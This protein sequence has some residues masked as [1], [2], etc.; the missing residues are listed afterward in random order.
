MAT[1]P[2]D[3]IDGAGPSPLPP[4]SRGGPSFTTTSR[5]DEVNNV[6]TW[7]RRIRAASKAY[8]SWADEYQVEQLERMY[9]GFQWGRQGNE[10]RPQDRYVVNLIFGDAETKMPALLFQRPSV[11]VQARPSLADDPSAG[12]QARVQ[13]VKDTAD[14]I[15][16]DPRSGFRVAH[17]LALKDSLFRFGVIAAFYDQDPMLTRDQE[18]MPPRKRNKDTEGVERPDLDETEGVDGT[19]GEMDE[20]PSP[21]PSLATPEPVAARIVYRWI[22]SKQFRVP[23]QNCNTLEENSWCGFFT[24]ESFDDVKNNNFFDPEAREQLT[25]GSA[26]AEFER[27]EMIQPP[28]QGSTASASNSRP[29]EDTTEA[30]Q[31]W[32]LWDIREKKR[33]VIS[34][35]SP[36]PLLSPEPYTTLPFSVLSFFER[37]GSFYPVPITWNW[38]HPQEEI[39]R[40]REDARIHRRRFYR[41]YLMRENAI[42][43]PELEKL[44]T[45]GDGVVAKVAGAGNG[46]LSD[47]LIP[48][49]DAPRDSNAYADA[50][51]LMQDM[52]L[53]S[54]VGGEQKGT[55][56][57]KTATQAALVES[58]ARLRQGWEKEVV[59]IWLASSITKCI[60]TAI[61]FFPVDYWIKVN[62]DTTGVGGAEEAFRVSGVWQ[63]IKLSDLNTFEWELAVD[64]ETL[65]PESSD[66]QRQQWSQVLGVFSQPQIMLFLLCS[67]MVLKKTL[68]LYGVRSSKDVSDVKRAMQVCLLANGLQVAVSAAEQANAISA[69]EDG[70]RGPGGGGMFDLGGLLPG[71]GG[72]ALPGGG[73]PTQIAQG[74]AGALATPGAGAGAPGPKGSPLMQLLAGLIGQGAGQ[75]GGMMG[76]GGR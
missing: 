72:G 5:T 50:Q 73:T 76:G 69:Q 48:V 37:L 6:K 19:N 21:F 75:V 68:A 44:E 64:V 43:Q 38:K 53:M 7:L 61:E 27:P 55:A 31:V 30:V 11:I 47:V 13:L 16:A 2:V 63:R 65:A 3:D 23:A 36:L 10:L 8:K 35:S 34:P 41:R 45:G 62:V 28:G 56:D 58:N 42:D 67:D 59:A 33:M 20:A 15:N 17:R 4:R 26:V 49:Q 32:W 71:A 18:R 52:R 74:G 57:A 40:E 66:L 1:P 22:P 12:I 46:P 14:T 25:P 51:I 54:N 60:K 39:N 9:Y 24:W 70:V 29:D